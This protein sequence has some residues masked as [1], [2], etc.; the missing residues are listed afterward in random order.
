MKLEN[1]E[2]TPVS[3][4][5]TQDDKVHPGLFPFYLSYM[6]T[7]RSLASTILLCSLLIAPIFTIIPPGQDVP[8]S[9]LGLSLSMLITLLSLTPHM[10][11]LRLL[12]L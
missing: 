10:G 7:V 4:I 1:H 6:H 11:N 12:K 9:L 8:L 5:P 2:L 3:F